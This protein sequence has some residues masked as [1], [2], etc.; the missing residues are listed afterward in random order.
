MKDVQLQIHSSED[1][2]YV[3]ISEL[4]ENEQEPFRKWL[5]GQTL[6]FIPNLE[7]QDAVFAWDYERWKRANRGEL[8][9]F[10]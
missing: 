2:A 1:F 5:I 9:A 10:D 6:P 3:R 8:V 4:P 7:P